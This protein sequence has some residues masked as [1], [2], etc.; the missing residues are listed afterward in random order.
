MKLL[1]RKNEFSFYLLSIPNT[2]NIWN[3]HLIV[4][5]CHIESVSWDSN[6]NEIIE[7]KIVNLTT[8]PFNYSHELVFLNQLLVLCKK[9]ENHNLVKSCKIESLVFN[10]VFKH[11]ALSLAL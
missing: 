7:R 1:Y 8:I 11:Q 10:E 4:K 2:I 9:E 6:F 3:Y 5:K